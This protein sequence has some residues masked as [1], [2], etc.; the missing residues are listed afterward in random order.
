MSAPVDFHCATNCGCDFL[1][2]FAATKID[3]GTVASATSASSGEIQNI[4]TSTPT[5]VS[6]EFSSC[7]I[8]CCSVWPML[9]MSF[10]ARLSTSPRFCWSKYD[11]GSRDS[12]AWSSSRIR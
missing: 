12:F 7:P 3:S 2:I 5:M 11:S 8:V 9:S 10:V 6:S 1:P 4:I